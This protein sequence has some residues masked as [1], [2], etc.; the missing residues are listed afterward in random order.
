MGDGGNRNHGGR[1]Q[2]PKRM[3]PVWTQIS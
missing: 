2:Q 1:S 3:T